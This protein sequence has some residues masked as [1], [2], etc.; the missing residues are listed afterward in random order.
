MKDIADMIITC[1]NWWVFL[2]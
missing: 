2:R 1:L